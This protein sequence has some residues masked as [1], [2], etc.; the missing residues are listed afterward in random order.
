MALFRVDF[1]SECFRHSVSLNVLI[2]SDFSGAPELTPPQGPYKTVYLLHGYRGNNTS[3]LLNSQVEEM[4]RQFNIAFVMPSGYNGFYV[5]AP[6][7]GIK[8]SRFIGSEL[9]DFTRKMFPLSR[10]REDTIIAGLSMGSYGTIYNSLKHGDVFGHAIALSAPIL[11]DRR[12]S[13]N[14]PKNSNMGLSEGFF[15]SLH[16]ATSKIMQTDR[17][18]ALFAK[19]TLDSGN[20]FSNL[21]I[22]CGYN[23]MLV[24]ENRDFVNQLKD[25][26]FPHFYEEG[27]GSHE[28]LFW[29]GFLRRGLRH[30]IG[31]EQYIMQSPFWIDAEGGGI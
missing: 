28:W 8:G 16:G 7:S 20:Q 30:A 11:P 9:I 10:K 23:D 2:P 14:E 21:Y 15:E 4:S 29:N 19:Q 17:N 27:P 22:A 24:S 26:S 31:D 1:F 13:K 6:R 5:D 18:L 12:L 3:W 25:M